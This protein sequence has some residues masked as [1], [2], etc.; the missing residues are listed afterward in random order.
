[1]YFLKLNI[2]TLINLHVLQNVNARPTLE[3]DSINTGTWHIWNNY[4][5]GKTSILC[6]L[7]LHHDTSDEFW[8][9]NVVNHAGL[10]YYNVGWLA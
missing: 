2:T 4:I 5:W 9:P 3:N 1:M 8:I 7:S 6:H 10:D